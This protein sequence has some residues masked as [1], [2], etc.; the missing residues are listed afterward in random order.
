MIQQR[1]VLFVSWDVVINIIPDASPDGLP[2]KQG[3]PTEPDVLCVAFQ[4]GEPDQNLGETDQTQDQSGASCTQ[5]IFKTS[6]SLR[7]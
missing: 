5:R 6:E 7:G 4:M 1:M 3:I 2:N